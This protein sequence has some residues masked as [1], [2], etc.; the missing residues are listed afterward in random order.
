M[1]N[2]C[3]RVA[4]ATVILAVT[5]SV[6]LAM[7][8]A[9]FWYAGG[10]VNYAGTNYYVAIQEFLEI[11]IDPGQP[12]SLF[13]NGVIKDTTNTHDW[14]TS[15]RDDAVYVGQIIDA[16]P[17]RW[18]VTMS[19][20]QTVK[21]HG[22]G[23]APHPSVPSSYYSAEVVHVGFGRVNGTSLV[24]EGANFH[25]GSKEGA[26]NSTW[27]YYT[28]PTDGFTV[29]RKVA[30]SGDLSNYTNSDG[31]PNTGWTNSVTIISA[32]ILCDIVDD[33][34][35]ARLFETPHVVVSRAGT[36]IIKQDVSLAVNLQGT[37]NAGDP[38]GDVTSTAEAWD[39]GTSTLLG[40]YTFK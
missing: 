19:T 23:G 8:T 14:S 16:D 34:Q 18:V 25:V 13:A 6:A 39:D 37:N 20:V 31:T 38:A 33:T 22:S 21:V 35:H 10:Y 26:V 24:W 36:I 3:I 30:S 29:A 11:A 4:F 2:Y 15:A 27:T 1:L 32:G 40:V 28:S 5:T 17:P 12:V 7:G 9:A